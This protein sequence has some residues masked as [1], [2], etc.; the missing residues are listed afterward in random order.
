M[1][2]KASNISL[3]QIKEAR[4]RIR[5]VIN[6]TPCIYSLPL[7]QKIGKEIFLKL[8]NLQIAQ[9]FKARGNSNKIALLDKQKKKKKKK[10]VIAA[11][12]GNHGLGLSL[13][14]LRND[15]K[16]VIVVPKVAPT[17]KI[18]KIKENKA[19]VII[20]GKTYDNAA[21]YAHSLAKKKDIFT[22]QV[23]MILT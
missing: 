18:E 13:A 9:A 4:E 11:S 16:A 19:E 14:A 20:E 10:G 23:L 5:K 1:F 12:S 6:K 7:S 17:N 8:E 21:S 22:F 2:S 15:I 3:I